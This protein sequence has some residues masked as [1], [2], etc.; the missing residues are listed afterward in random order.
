MVTRTAPEPDGEGDEMTPKIRYYDRQIRYWT[1][2]KEHELLKLGASD[3]SDGKENEKERSKGKDKENNNHHN[4]ARARVSVFA[5]EIP[6]LEEVKAE[7]ERIGSDVD[8]EV[9][10]NYYSAKNKGWPKEWKSAL[11]VWTKNGN[12]RGR[13]RAAAPAAEQPV[14]R[15]Y[16]ASDWCLCA[17]RCANFRDGRCSCGVTV[18]PDKDPVRQTPPE[19]CRGFAAVVQE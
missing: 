2:L 18:P 6:S 15:S 17:E 12:P 4:R 16:T 11:V 10:W 13:I 3:A 9:F 7:C 19:E 5:G 8:P 1:K 14:R